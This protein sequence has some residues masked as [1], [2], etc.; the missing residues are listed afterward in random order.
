MRRPEVQRIAFCLGQLQQ[1]RLFRELSALEGLKLQVEG[2]D[3][4]RCMPIKKI[5]LKVVGMWPPLFASDKFPVVRLQT[6]QG[7]TPRSPAC[8]VQ[9]F[10]TQILR[11]HLLILA[12]QTNYHHKLRQKFLL[13]A[14]HASAP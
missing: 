9:R 1:M 7:L 11:R 10:V 2:L 4:L 3:W 6:W 13:T 5:G 8:P 14:E 12:T